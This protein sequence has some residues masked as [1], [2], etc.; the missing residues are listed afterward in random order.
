MIECF[1]YWLKL[2]Q[3]VALNQNTEEKCSGET[4]ASRIFFIF[5]FPQ[6]KKNAVE[7]ECQHED[8]PWKDIEL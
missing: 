1:D 8:V 5:F 4:P 2:P 6:Q 3:P 7:E